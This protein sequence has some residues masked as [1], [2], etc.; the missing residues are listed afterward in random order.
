MYMV[1]F[2]RGTYAWLRQALLHFHLERA[3]R[4]AHLTPEGAAV[5]GDAYIALYAVRA[6]ACET[7]ARLAAGETPGPETSV[8]KLLLS[9]AEQAVFDAVRYLNWPALETGDSNDA[10]ALRVA[11]FYT[12]AASIFGG[13]AEV[14]RDIVAERL[15]GLP[16][17]R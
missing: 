15:L 5:V 6:R 8:D 4:N 7:V 3:C 2:E 17:S 14:Q 12:R 13:A 16:R 1:Q 10:S 11:W 9:T